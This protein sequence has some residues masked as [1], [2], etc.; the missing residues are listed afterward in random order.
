MM[1]RCLTPGEVAR[2]MRV[3]INTVRRWVYAGRLRGI[4]VSERG[5]VRIRPE[6]LEQFVATNMTGK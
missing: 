2:L 3:H 1:D 4:R 6:D 5:D